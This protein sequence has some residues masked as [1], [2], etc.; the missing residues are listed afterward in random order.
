MQE[1]ATTFKS[2]DVG[3]PWEIHFKVK[4]Q[5]EATDLK[6]IFQFSVQLLADV[7]KSDP[8][9]DNNIACLTKHLLTI[10]E[11]ILTWGYIPPM[12]ILLCISIFYYCISYFYVQKSNMQ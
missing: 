10:A 7:T 12:Y 3:L 4:K 5:F 2:T 8:P 11:N 1:Y 6:R 9:Y